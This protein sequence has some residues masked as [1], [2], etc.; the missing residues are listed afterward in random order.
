MPRELVIN[1]TRIDDDS[2]CYVIAEIGHN[3]Q[4][5]VEK[6]KELFRR[7]KECGASAVKL[8]KRDNRT[9]FT[10]AAFDRPYDNENSFGPT[11]GLHREA[12][13]LRG[14]EFRELKRYAEEVVGIDFFA[15]AFDIPSADVLADLDIPVFKLAS[16]DLTNIPLLKHVARFGKPM[17]VSTGGGTMEDVERAYEAIIGINSQVCLLQ[18]TSSYPAEPEDLDLCVIE[19]FRERFPETVIGFSGH[20]NGIAMPLVAYILGARVI[21]KHFTLNR[22][23]KGTDHIFSLEPVG[24]RK[25][26]RDLTRAREALGDGVKKRHTSEV[27]SMLKMGK[28]LYAARDLPAGHILSEGDVAIR[29]PGGGLAPYEL[30]RIVGL[31]LG[32][33]LATDDPIT[34]EALAG[35]PRPAGALLAAAPR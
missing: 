13:E 11:Y 4:G 5:D 15:T 33:S 8:Q 26:V 35:E 12:L 3:H 27:A 10:R 7:A 32:Q 2:P 28:S 6:A 34:L 30:E 9:L 22:T 18:C 25:L 16:S 14:D 19:T 21:E 29:C 23:M 17:I 31:P 1:G 20:D 24:L